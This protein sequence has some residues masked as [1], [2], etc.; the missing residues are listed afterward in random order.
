MD[1]LNGAQHSIFRFEYLQDFSATDR[2][3][4]AKWQNHELDIAQ[5]GKGWWNDLRVL[6]KRGVVT[7]RVRRVVR[8][9]NDYTK[10]ELE[11]H[12]ESAR[13]GDKIKIIDDDLFQVF[14]VN[15]RDFW[16]VDDK[17]ALKMNYGDAGRY[18]GFSI[19]EDVEKYVKAKELLWR[20]SLP[21][22]EKFIPEI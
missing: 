8:P 19:D 17:T 1:Y 7:Q 21:I 12:K 9:M 20:H 6:H 11:I 3:E 14:N 16:L 10:F 4:F 15:L 13:H 18:E 22:G 2:D 5:L